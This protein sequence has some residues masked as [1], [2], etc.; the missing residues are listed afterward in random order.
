MPRT[1]V[2]NELRLRRILDA[3]R[4]VITRAQ[5]F[6]CGLTPKALEYRLR[7]DG[8]WQW[9]LPSVYAAVTGSLSVSQDQREVA[10][11]LY[12]GPVSL[13]TGPTAV[14]RHHLTCA[15][16]DT[17]DILIP[18][19]ARRQ[20][21][22]FVRVHRT[23]RIP[24]RCFTNGAIAYVKQV[25]AVADAARILTRFDD[26]RAVVSEA[27]LRRVCTL[28]DLT[29]ELNAGGI[30]RSGLFREALAEVRDGIRSVAEAE[31]RR[32][33]LGSGLPVPM[34]NAQLFD[35]A[36]TFIAMVDAW[37]DRAGVAA[38]VDSRAYH[39]SADDQ[40]YT[41]ERHAELAAHGILPLHFA[42]KAI[43]K[44]GPAVI[45][46]IERAISNGLDRPPLPISAVPLAA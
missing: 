8:S 23:R 39:L 3:Q 13:I 45:G 27:L 24:E 26:V 42:P 29:E 19:N 18:W 33:L 14:R 21:T 15:G 1:L 28:E 22:R 4:Q 20:S 30:P 37:W 2:F 40:D 34:F 35:A 11:R 43:R 32:L 6:S 36:G 10:A 9:L 41:N 44:S 12:A 5:A 7:P 31:F 46:K 25:R 38:E 17:I 16:P